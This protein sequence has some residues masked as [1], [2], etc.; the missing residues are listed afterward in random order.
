MKTLGISTQVES[1][2][3]TLQDTRV[4]LCRSRGF[5]LRYE[6]E[7]RISPSLSIHE[8]VRVGN[9][10]EV[11]AHPDLNLGQAV[12]DFVTDVE[13]VVRRP[14]VVHAGGNSDVWAEEILHTNLTSEGDAI[15]TE[16]LSASAQQWSSTRC[17]EG[18]FL[19]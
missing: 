9:V 1:W 8:I 12:T 17:D 14:V 13:D 11:E 16:L 3:P 15:D 18:V 4:A 2:E 5:R 6:K 10:L 19:H 7:R